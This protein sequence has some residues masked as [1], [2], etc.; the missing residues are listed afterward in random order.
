[1][2]QEKTLESGF[3]LKGNHDYTI[4]KTINRGGFGVTY[5]AEAEFMDHHISQM[6][7]YAIKEFFPEGMCHRNDD[8]SVAPLD[9][10]KS[11]FK[12]SYDEFKAEADCLYGLHH[13]GIVPVNEVIEVNG[14]LY[15]V[16]KFLRGKTL[17]EYVSGKGG[18]LDEDEAIGIVAKVADAI[19]YLHEQSILHLDVK[20]DNIMMTSAGPVLI[21]F[22]SFRRYKTNG[23]L[24]TKKSAR[25]VSDGFSPQE[26]YKGIDTFTPQAD[27]YAL[28]AT[29]YYMLS[30]ETPVEAG[31]MSKKWVY[32]NVPKGVS[33]QTTEVLANALAKAVDDRTES[34]SKMVTALHG[35]PVGTERKK[36]K[37]TRLLEDEEKEKKAKMMKMVGAAVAVVAAC[38]LLF[39]LLRPSADKPSAGGNDTVATADSVKADSTTTVQTETAVVSPTATEGN[40]QTQETVTQTAAPATPP[41]T[42]PAVATQT[43]AQAP[44]STPVPAAE[45]A[46]AKPVA[47]TSGTLD[48]GYAVWNGGIANGKPDGKG[49]MTFKSSHL[50]DSRDIGQNTASAGDQIEGKYS[51]GHLVYGTWT[52]TSGET[53]KLMIG[54]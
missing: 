49:T 46:P 6:G 16:M 33:E 13:E 51:N 47:A 3:I 40:T 11:S 50:I 54:Q 48:L 19:R 29:L 17:E 22:G 45:T 5:L 26:Q 9:S 23:K 25:C 53:K 35:K 30:G 42:T 36:K 44:A 15:Y 10:R 14:T 34:V 2:E 37:G 12:E 31:Q 20:P 1:M 27:V 4:L 41:Q 24:D 7:T 21:D 8:Q 32:V 38:L 39:F 28:G 52:K 43:P 18:Q